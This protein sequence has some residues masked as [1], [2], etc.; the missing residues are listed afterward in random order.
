MKNLFLTKKV[1]QKISQIHKIARTETDCKASRLNRGIFLESFAVNGGGLR[2]NRYIRPHWQTL[3]G[4]CRHRHGT[5][6]LER[7][8]RLPQE[9]HC[10]MA[11]PQTT[12]GRETQ[13]NW[14]IKINQSTGKS[15]L[16]TTAF[17]ERCTLFSW[18]VSLPTLLWNKTSTQKD[19]VPFFLFF[20]VSSNAARGHWY[21]CC[22]VV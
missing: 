15:S 14:L 13:R 6:S 3:A 7:H 18:I 5:P 12:G 16:Y 8:A 19:F 9:T 1:F 4:L 21:L 22:D 11:H 17:H 10:S 2:P 20:F